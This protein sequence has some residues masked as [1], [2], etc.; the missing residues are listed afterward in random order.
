MP[1]TVKSTSNTDLLLKHLKDGSLASRLVEAHRNR[2]PAD[3]PDSMRAV[4][5]ERLEQARRE[6]DG[7]KA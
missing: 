7:T 2:S 4:L 5:R 1:D 6:I 3:S